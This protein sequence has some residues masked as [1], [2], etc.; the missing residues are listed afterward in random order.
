M[1]LHDYL[2]PYNFP[3]GC[4]VRV[5]RLSSQLLYNSAAYNYYK[6]ALY[7]NKT[8]NNQ[9]QLFKKGA[10]NYCI[11]DISNSLLTNALI[12]STLNDF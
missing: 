5:P 2:T 11:I 9:V 8:V 10:F 4:K 7:H 1:R 3:L 6:A 12:K